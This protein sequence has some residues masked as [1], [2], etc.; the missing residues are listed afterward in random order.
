MKIYRN[1]VGVFFH[2]SSNIQIQNSY[3]SDNALSIDIERTLSS[4]IRFLNIT[5]I[6]ESDVY[7]NNVRLKQLD[8]VCDKAYGLPSY[9]IGIEVRAWRDRVGMAGSIWQDIEFSNFNHT[10]CSYVSPI[11]MDYTVRYILIKF[12][13]SEW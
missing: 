6:G 1:N 10:T 8:D 11:S 2:I 4:P 13:T 9:N 7:R 3:F 5:V 12:E